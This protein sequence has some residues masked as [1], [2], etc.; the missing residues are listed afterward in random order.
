M[1][2][3]R[4]LLAVPVALLA[5]AGAAHGGKSLTGFGKPAP[6]APP[7]VRP[8][9]AFVESY[10]SN[11]DVEAGHF[12]LDTRIPLD[13]SDVATFDESTYFDVS[14]GYF[15][16]GAYLSDDPNWK[17]GM[18]TAT[19]TDVGY[20]GD[21]QLVARLRWTPT[22]LFVH[23]VAATGDDVDPIMSDDYAGD[24]TGP[25]ADDPDIEPSAE[26]QLG[27][28]DVSFDAVPCAG[29]VVSWTT[30]AGD[31]FSVVKMH[32]RAVLPAQ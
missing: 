22:Q 12:V 31:D 6:K 4:A 14:V 8:L 19:L 29:R 10:V 20:D 2:T 3:A 7:P 11:P 16:F 5:L 27:N 28:A 23:V 25:I 24:D 21:T 30:K 13:P 18:T 32:G 15:D 9:V 1:T 17:P 26:I